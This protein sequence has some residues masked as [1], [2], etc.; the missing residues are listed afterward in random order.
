MVLAITQLRIEKLTALQMKLFMLFCHSLQ[1]NELCIDL[2][3]VWKLVQISNTP[4]HNLISHSNCNL[5]IRFHLIIALTATRVVAYFPSF[6]PVI[7]SHKARG[8]PGRRNRSHNY[9]GDSTPI[10]QVSCSSLF[11]IASVRPTILKLQ[12]PWMSGVTFPASLL[13]GSE[14]LWNFRELIWSWVSESPWIWAGWSLTALWEKAFSANGVWPGRS[15]IV[16]GIHATL[17]VNSLVDSTGSSDLLHF[18]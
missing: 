10:R 16:P 4:L 8:L 18:W 11:S 15:G 3:T 1:E 2:L 13:E 17:K 5:N 12:K 14:M 9:S 6:S 7:L